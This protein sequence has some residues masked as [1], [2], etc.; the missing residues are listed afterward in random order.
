MSKKCGIS[1]S[2]DDENFLKFFI[3]VMD[4]QL[5]EYTTSY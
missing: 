2:G 5:Y 4:A 3:V 1:F